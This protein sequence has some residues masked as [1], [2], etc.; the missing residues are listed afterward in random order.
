MGDERT[1]RICATRSAKGRDEIFLAEGS[2][3][4][5]RANCGRYHSSTRSD[6]PLGGARL[7]LRFRSSK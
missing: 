5:V 2:S 7:I 6:D 4:S 3:F 1:L